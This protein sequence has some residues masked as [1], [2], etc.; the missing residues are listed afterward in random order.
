VPEFTRFYTE[1]WAFAPGYGRY[2]GLVDTCRQHFRGF[3]C[4]V[5]M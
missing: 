3:C 4:R 1:A 2:C 5:Q